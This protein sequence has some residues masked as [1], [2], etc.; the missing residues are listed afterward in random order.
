MDMAR[1]PASDP[2]D[3]PVAPEGALGGVPVID[4][5]DPA[6]MVVG[7]V[8]AACREWGFFQ[9]VGHGVPADLTEAV[10][11][12]AK[13][14]FARPR[15]EKRRCLRSRDNP[16]GYYDREL[17]KEQRDRKEIFDIGPDATLQDLPSDDPFAGATPWPEQPANFPDVMERWAAQMN[18]LSG[19][20]IGMIGASLTGEAET[21]RR[22]FEPSHTSYLRLNYY[23]VE[24]ALAAETGTEADLGIHHHTDAG[25]LTVLLQD[26]VSGLQVYRDGSWHNVT[27]VPGAFTVNIGDMVQVWSNDAYPAALHRVLAMDRAERI[28]IPYFY[29]PSYE[30][31]VLPLTGDPKYRPIDWGEFRRRRADGD[32]ANYG[33]EVQISQYRRDAA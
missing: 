30:T 21:L 23:P 12:A 2:D 3:A 28:S 7:R 20:L 19:Q 31:E 10:L 33:T 32:F 4:L 5:R 16:W 15:E 8:G 1:P 6:E 26:G 29:N 13:T 25:A 14:F 9:I 24:D 27:A 22:A 11:R 18:R 17:T